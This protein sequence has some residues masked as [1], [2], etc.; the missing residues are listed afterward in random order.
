MIRKL[1]SVAA[2]ICI[3]SGFL[4]FTEPV[5]A[6]T[7]QPVTASA[8]STDQ[9]KATARAMAKFNEKKARIGGGR[10]T[11]SSTTCSKSVGVYTCKAKAVVCP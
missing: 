6:G 10:I 3:A 4:V 7:C 1:F 2:A 5:E 11:Q 9:T 8:R